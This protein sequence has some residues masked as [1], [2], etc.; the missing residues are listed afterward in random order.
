MRQ[1][2]SILY[3][4]YLHIYRYLSE[5]IYPTYNNNIY[6]CERVDLG[7]LLFIYY[8]AEMCIYIIG[9]DH[10]QWRIAG[11]FRRQGKGVN[12]DVEKN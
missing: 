4:I 11:I 1:N 7:E 2:C 12:V 3:I 5:Y 6:E 8:Y 9:L 10:Y